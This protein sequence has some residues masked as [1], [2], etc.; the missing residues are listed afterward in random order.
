MGL[1]E[2]TKKDCSL[3]SEKKKE[4]FAEQY[5]SEYYK[6]IQARQRRDLQ[7][8]REKATEAVSGD[9]LHDCLW[10]D[11]SKPAS[12]FRQEREAVRGACLD[13]EI[14]QYE[15]VYGPLQA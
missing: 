10:C 2:D 13:C 1:S 12:Q 6:K 11:A 5:Y 7:N 15:K 9:N 4:E 8:A 3:F 14:D